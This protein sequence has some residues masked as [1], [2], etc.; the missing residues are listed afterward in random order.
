MGVYVKNKRTVLRGFLFTSRD[1][2]SSTTNS[3]MRLY[4]LWAAFIWRH[5]SLKS[6][7]LKGGLMPF[8]KISYFYLFLT[9]DQS[10]H[11]FWFIPPSNVMIFLRFI[12]KKNRIIHPAKYFPIFTCFTAVWRKERQKCSTLGHEQWNLRL[13][14]EGRLLDF[15]L[16]GATTSNV[17]FVAV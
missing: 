1:D 11:Y 14:F 16:Q 17:V 6:T 5:P 8:N 4:F 2:F 7:S 12:V 13:T 10:E 9:S 3:K 15:F